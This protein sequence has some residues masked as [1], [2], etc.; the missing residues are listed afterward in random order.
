MIIGENFVEG[1]SNYETERP[2]NQ[3]LRR[4]PMQLYKTEVILF[5]WLQA[6]LG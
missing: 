6:N 5:G 2:I 3:K 1:P 4:F